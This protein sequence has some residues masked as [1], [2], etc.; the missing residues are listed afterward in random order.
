LMAIG[1]LRTGTRLAILR[2][3]SSH[4]RK[5]TVVC[6]ARRALG[7]HHHRGAVGRRTSRQSISALALPWAVHGYFRRNLT[8]MVC[9]KRPVSA[10]GQI[11]RLHCA[12]LPPCC[13]DRGRI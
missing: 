10:F 12:N 9:I 2:C 3:G 7:P 13:S 11:E 8:A 4:D 1:R 5:K 6:P